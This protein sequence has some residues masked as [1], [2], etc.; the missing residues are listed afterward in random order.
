[1]TVNKF[2]RKLLNL[3]ELSVSGFE[4]KRQQKRLTLFVKTYKNGCQCPVCNRRGKIKNQTQTGR[5]W[6]DLPIYGCRVELS[7]CPREFI[8][9]RH[10]RVQ[11]NIPWAGTYLRVTY[12]FEY[13][14]LTYCQIMTQKAAAMLLHISTSTLSDLLHRAIRTYSRWPPDPGL[15]IH[16]R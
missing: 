11:E 9:P 10:G 15:K 13:A 5:V 1:M 12:R 3:K 4:L 2:I 14:M 16:W 7:Y 6:R 8:C